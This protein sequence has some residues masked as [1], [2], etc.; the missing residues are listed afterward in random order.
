MWSIITRHALRAA[1]ICS[2]CLAAATAAQAVTVRGRTIDAHT[3]K[4]LVAATVRIAEAEQSMATDS[5]GQFVFESV[6]AGNYTLTASFVGYTPARISAR[7][8]ID[9]IRVELRLDPVVL[10]GEEVIITTTRV[11]MQTDAVSHSNITREQIERD[12][13]VE[14]VPMYL[15]KEPGVYA[16]SDAGNGVGYTYMQ[17]RGFDQR[18]VSVLIN[19]V[20]HND[21]E[22][23][24]VYWI[25]V[26]D[27]MASA[28]DIQI[29]RGVG[30]SLYGASAAGGVISMEVNPFTSKPRLNLDFGYGS[31]GTKRF[32][33][34]GKSGLVADRY[35]IYGR[36]SR[37]E[38][39]GY[40]DQ[41]WVDMWSYFVGV[42]RYDGNLVN[43]FHAYGGP[44]HLHLA[45]LGIDPPTLDT[46]RRF[47]PLGYDGETDTFNQPHYELLTDW[48]ISESLSL[49]NSLFYIKGDGFFIQSWPW[50]SFAALELD[51]IQTRDSLTFDPIH[52]ETVVLDTQYVLDTADGLWYQ[53]ENTTYRRDTL[54]SGDTVFTVSQFNNA[55]LQ[56][57]VQND[58]VGIAP[59]F[60]LDHSRGSLQFGG[61]FNYHH[62]YHFGQVRSADPAP[63]GFQAGEDYYNYDGYRTS[64]IAF[65]QENRQFFGKLHASLGLQFA[66]RRYSLRN[67]RRG[68][69]HYDLDYTAFSPRLGAVYRFTSVHSVYGNLSY[70]EHEPAH[71]DIYNPAELED[72]SRFFQNYDPATGR[73]SVPVMSDEQVTSIDVG[74]RLRNER[75]HIAVNGFYQRFDNEIVPASG[76]D[77]DGNPIRT[78]AGRTI[79]RGVEALLKYRPASIVELTANATW[80]EN[81]FDDFTEYFWTLESSQS[82]DTVFLP[83]AALDS[84]SRSGNSI[85]GF[86]ELSVNAGIY[87]DQPV[88]RGGMHLL[89]GIEYRHI[90]RIYLDN[91]G[92]Q[93]LSIDPFDVLNVRIGIRTGGFGVGQSFVVELIANNVT[94]TLYTPSGYTWFGVPYYYP[95]ADRNFFLRIRTSW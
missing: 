60:K 80:S 1:I 71:T 43:R 23:H 28:T 44:E 95:A 67:D 26:P 92:N 15:A 82:N 75:A 35:S 50:S 38:S 66:W 51:P 68:G 94:N 88:R 7:L 33:L 12:Y 48:K 19:G 47:N 14:D 4:P 76:I 21:P 49:S 91:S 39:N 11:S 20:P 30:A 17:V 25:D 46:N 37:I 54:P 73:A 70:A 8:G 79:H 16:Y 42:A 9:D 86:P 69:V 59:R 22:S 65:V 89:G 2:C 81:Y 53:V 74:Y 85:A 63:E 62:G 13:T 87:V 72:P 84:V 3:G 36:Y 57:W 56:R 55:V 40:R 5:L 52:Y 90:G 77:I 10:P 45:Y 18:K 34:E 29:Q 93:A 32:M 83:R 6:P 41:S 61:S 78:N 27:L 24:Q 64:A 58:F 31:F